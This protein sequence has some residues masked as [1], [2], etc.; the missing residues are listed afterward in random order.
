MIEIKH[1][2]TG[3]VLYSSDVIDVKTCLV[4]AVKARA[5]LQ[6]ADLHDADLHDANLQGANFQG[7][8]LH[9]ANFQGANLHGAN[10]R[11]ANLHDANLQSADL[12]RANLQG[13]NLHGANLRDAN[14]HDAN[15]QRANLQRANLQGATLQG[16]NLQGANLQGALNI[17]ILA[18]AQASIVPAGAL[19]GWKKLGGGLIACLDIPHD[20]SRVNA[21]G[22][23]KCRAAFAYVRSIVDGAEAK[24]E[25]FATHNN[26]KYTVGQIVQPDDYD[27]SNLIECSHG[28]HF[29]ITREEAE[30]H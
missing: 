2:I 26:M 17:P 6:G 8:D 3:A 22:S 13:A 29:F 20:A 12:Q 18:Q 21:I 11:D 10:L 16:A 27:G 5:N 23:R 24:T 19:V 14:L 7:A 28:I 30:A 15:L 1:R 4:A 25:G 9:G